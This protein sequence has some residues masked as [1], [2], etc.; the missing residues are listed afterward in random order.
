MTLVRVELVHDD[1]ELVGSLFERNADVVALQ[2]LDDRSRPDAYCVLPHGS[3]SRIRVL[4]S[5]SIESKSVA[6]QKIIFRRPRDVRFDNLQTAIETLSAHFW[7]VSVF[8]E[9]LRPDECM[10]GW[11]TDLNAEK[12]T[13]RKIDPNGKVVKRPKQL[14]LKDVTRLDSGG[15]YERVLR[16]VVESENSPEDSG[17]VGSNTNPRRRSP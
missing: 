3:I 6:V 10:I 16:A 1:V 13:L 2:L 9:R 4:R 7:L 12:M 5:T 17:R 15:G 14:L 11:V 8:V